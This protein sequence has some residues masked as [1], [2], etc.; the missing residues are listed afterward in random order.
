[1]TC[2]VEETCQDNVYPYSVKASKK[3]GAVEETMQ[4]TRKTRLQMI[5]DFYQL[6]KLG[7]A[8]IGTQKGVE[9]SALVVLP[10][11]VRIVHVGM[12][13]ACLECA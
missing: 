7:N 3:G 11:D 13:S 6:R 5:G 4:I 9:C 1:M 8:L 2:E 10:E 12:P